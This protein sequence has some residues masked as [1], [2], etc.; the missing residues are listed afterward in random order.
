MQ[1]QPTPARLVPSSSGVL[2]VDGYGVW[3]RVEHGHLLVADGIGRRRRGGQFPRA[4]SGLRRLVVL[5]HTGAVTF[6]ALRWL[7][8]TGVGY[9]ALDSDGR[10]L[11]ASANLG[12]DD[13][14][15][16]RAQAQAIDTPTGDAIA[17]RLIAEKVAAQAETLGVVD[18]VSPV[19][20]ATIAVLRDAAGRLHVATSR[21]EIRQAEA[22]AAAAYWSAWAAVP[23]RFARRDLGRVPEAWLTF[24]ARTSPLT[25]SP[26]LAVNPAN[27]VLNYLYAILE[28]EARLAC[29]AVGL[30]AGLGVLHADQKARDSLAL[31][32]VE[33]IRPLVDRFALRVL[34]DRALRA[35]DFVETRQGVCRVLEPLSHELA[36]TMLDWRAH[37]GAVAERVA[38]LLVV[39]AA[40]S[41]RQPTP[42]TGRNRSAGRGASSRRLPHDRGETR[43]VARACAS[44]GAAVSGGRRLCDRCLPA[45]RVER[46]TGFVA[47]G[48]ARLAE[49]RAAGVKPGIGGTAAAARGAKVAASRAAARAWERENPGPIDPGEFRLRVLP[50]LAGLTAAG[51]AAAT[52]LSRA[53]CGAIQRGDRIPHPRWWQTL[54]EGARWAAG[55]GPARSSSSTV[56]RARHNESPDPSSTDCGSQSPPGDLVG[57]RFRTRYDATIKGNGELSAAPERPPVSLPAAGTG[58][59]PAP[60]GQAIGRRHWTR[61]RRPQ[62]PCG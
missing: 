34:I 12:R 48:N 44:C 41:E 10:L 43:S 28:A 17:R 57:R 53:Y 25:A 21:D 2:V 35:V 19:D 8:D 42:L 11:A 1:P 16:R 55:T 4:G 18:R 22:M 54:E 51:L 32:V 40:A 7:A 38:A 15:L 5:G 9:V 23:V 3:V 46:A 62:G 6:D 29:L 33:P 37:V 52:G 30:D 24:G 58:S 39:D 56:T 45:D 59:P 27:A 61:P 13:P 31:D 50:H 14:R 36:G 47:A 20:E 26:R 60:G 49:L